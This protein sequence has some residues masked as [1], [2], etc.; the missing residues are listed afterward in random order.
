MAGKANYRFEVTENAGK[1]D[2]EHYVTVDEEIVYIHVQVKSRE[3]RVFPAVTCRVIVPACGVYDIWTPKINLI[4][5]LNQDWFEYLNRTNGFTGAPVQCLIGHKDENC[6]ALGLSDT[7]N[8]IGLYSY[9]IEESGEYAFTIELFREDTIVKKEY[10][11]TI[12]LDMRSCS[13]Y[14][15]LNDMTKWWE[16]EEQNKPA[17][18]PEKAGEAMYSTWYSY[19]QMVSEEALLKEC[20]YAKTLG[21]ETLLLDDG[22]QTEDMNRGY[23]YCG[24]WEPAK[25]K[26]PNMKKFVERVHEEGM[27]IMLWYSLPFIGEKSKNFEK[28]KDMLIDP[29][30]K[31]EWHVLDPR[32]PEVRE[33]IVS[34]FERAL[35]EWQVDGFKMDFIDEFVVTPF[36]GKDKDTRRDYESFHEASDKMMKECV[37]RLKKIK[38]DI[39]LEF[40]QTYNGP[41]MRSYGNIFRAV[42][43][44]FDAVENRTRVTDIR[45]L[46]GDSAVHSDMIMWNTE[47]TPENAALQFINILFSVPQIS[48]RLEELPGAHY[49]MLKFYCGLWKKYKNAFMKGR[50][51]PLYPESRYSVIKGIWKQQLVCVYHGNHV[52]SLNQMYEEMVFVNG[53]SEPKLYIYNGDKENDY[54]VSIY[55]CQGQLLK[56]ETKHI[57]IGI[58]EVT[59]PVSG[60]S[61]LKKPC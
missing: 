50:F 58:Q 7:L 55:D 6:A 46:C 49:Q 32:Y 52:I 56:E 33:F 29:A 17:A 16:Q 51:E 48:M 3:P 35:E 30:A 11:F 43:C 34:L 40:R 41:L 39:L 13:Y 19:H 47:D 54:R 57:S 53:S 59:V 27:G 25:S 21:C 28:F 42:D 37:S 44:P 60:V 5:A 23:A 9:P 20:K 15:V 18:V 1:L 14:E 38:P 2:I 61:V 24:D 4:K 26:I 8:T 12:R 31:R 36:S 10:D 22:W 45:L